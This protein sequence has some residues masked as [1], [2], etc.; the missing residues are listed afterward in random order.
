MA[1][2]LIKKALLPDG[3]DGYSVA[4]V[5]SRL[6]RAAGYRSRAL[7]SAEKGM[8]YWSNQLSFALA[9]EGSRPWAKPTLSTEELR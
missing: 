4:Y 3:D 2:Q 5:R 7:K 8:E 6:D 1:D 9:R